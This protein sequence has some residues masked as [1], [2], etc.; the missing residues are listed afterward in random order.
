MIFEYVSRTEGAS[1]LIL[2]FAGW[3]MDSRPF[4]DLRFGEYDIAVVYDY[5]HFDFPADLS[6]Y[7][8]IVVIAWS[9]G[10]VGA[11]Y[12]L[13]S[14]PGLPITATIAINGTPEAV[15]DRK[16]IPSGIFEATLDALTPASL[17]KFYRRTAGKN[18][19]QFLTRLPQRDFNGLADELKA[20]RTACG[21]KGVR[22][23]KAIVGAND[24]IIPAEN[25]RH[26]WEG[27]TAEIIG[28]NID[29]LPDFPRLFSRH[30][31]DKRLVATRFSR[32]VGSYDD[33][34]DVQRQI[35]RK[36]ADALPSSVPTDIDII[37]IGCGSGYSTRLLLK[38][39]PDAHLKL[40]DIH[41]WPDICGHAVEQTDGEIWMR[42]VPSESADM[43][44]SV[45]AVQWFNS[46]PAFLRQCS[47]VLRPGGS[48]VLT[49]FGTETMKQLR[50]IGA[51]TRHYPSAEFISGLLKGEGWSDI[52]VTTEE[53]VRRFD[54]PKDL[55]AHLR[56][57]GV[58]A[59]SSASPTADALAIMRSYPFDPDGRISLTYQP[60]YIT[61]TWPK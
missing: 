59:I 38:R 54:T 56:Q 30:L 17:T 40:A 5:R 13:A 3:A 12:F 32:A 22:W 55:L 41:S 57:T 33:S 9:F 18:F 49:T 35:A 53:I 37:E 19:R 51:A 29:H 52:S 7:S 16:G 45:S 15:D 20:V 26:S 39:Y 4:S 31:T 58:N 42:S 21:R 43:I 14:N 24:L 61:A 47:R 10:V 6:N 46:L 50:T 27:H 1:R 25:Q 8:E 34:A 28:D 44:Y 36:I 23:D 11:E 48:L 2:I 60:V